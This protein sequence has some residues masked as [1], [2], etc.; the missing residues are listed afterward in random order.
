MANNSL[1]IDK[2]LSFQP[3]A[4]APADPRPGQLYVDSTDSNKLKQYVQN[5][6]WVAVGDVQGLAGSDWTVYPL[7]IGSTGTPPTKGTAAVDIARWRRVGGNMEIEFNYQQ[8]AGGADGTGDYLFP[9]P[10]GYA[11]DTA[12]QP[13]SAV[14]FNNVV[15]TIKMS[16]DATGS[17]STTIN[18]VVVAY[19]TTNL[20]AL[21]VNNP[22]GFLKS[23]SFTVGG[24]GFALSNTDII[25]NVRATVPIQ[26]WSANVTMA[27]DPAAL[28][29]AVSYFLS[30]NQA[31][32]ADVTD[33]NFDTMLYDPKGLFSAG[34]F[35]ADVAGMYTIV[36]SGSTT[37][38]AVAPVLYK[39]G[40][41]YA[42]LA[43]WNNTVVQTS[44]IS[45]PLSV[46]DTISIRSNTT[47]A[48]YGQTL[49]NGGSSLSIARAV[50]STSL[51]IDSIRSSITV[52]TGNGHGSTATTIR[53]FTNVI[54][55]TGA[56]IVYADSATDGNTFTIQTPG[57]YAIAYS[58][59]Y[60]GGI[61]DFG[62]SVNA[63]VLTDSITDIPAVNRLSITSSSA[64]GSNGNCSVTVA[65]SG[66]DV[67]RAHTNGQPNGASIRTAFTITKV[68][69]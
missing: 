13:V 8:T 50:G 45:V 10:A 12:L 6:G 24:S 1:R 47:D 53:R 44:T 48:I 21:S 62:I 27:S 11:I 35:T 4:T 64:G 37:T 5:V 20:I 65:L 7:T 57:I 68:A 33:I 67:V 38:G 59:Y 54:S 49:A 29:S 16:S 69:T 40:V 36:T 60:A 28:P 34:V 63:P 9:L 15:G 51:A 55:S 3:Q 42:F 39:N 52:D 41:A 46:G 19:D 30:A 23:D 2:S 32:T 61:A 66:G 22:A 43:N 17:A 31:V 26:G 58:D 18:G 14:N 56:D 25:F